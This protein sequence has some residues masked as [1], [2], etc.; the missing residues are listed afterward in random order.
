VSKD[1]VRFVDVGDARMAYRMRGSGPPVLLVH[2]WPLSG[3]TWEKLVPHLEG[4]FT[5]IRVD[6]AGTGETEWDA[7][8]DFRFPAH[9]RRL[10]AFLDQLKLDACDIVAQDTGATITRLLAADDAGRRIQRMVLLNTELPDHRPPWIPLYRL[11]M[12]LPGANLSFRL[13]L[14]SRAY[15]HSS[16]G[17]GGCFHDTGLIDGDFM[18]RI[19]APLMKSPRRMEGL[20][21]Y[22]R[23]LDWRVV[24]GLRTT[25]A[26]IRIPVLL[27]WGE[28]DPTFPPQEARRIVEQFPDCRGMKLIPKTRLFPHEERPDLVA[29][30]LRSFL[31]P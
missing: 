19:L 31:A 26:A 23:A 4:Q 12:F 17:F 13:L 15:L 24:D 28:D 27:V 11:M 18:D 3:L 14:R 2:G 10:S 16:L 7:R 6:L 1:P 22:M 9:A 21:R 8:T 30:E 5:C 29:A 20:I 25:H